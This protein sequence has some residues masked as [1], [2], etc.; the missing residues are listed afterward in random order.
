MAAFRP[1]APGVNSPSGSRP[2]ARSR[3]TAR[4]EHR[5]FPTRETVHKS[6][7][8][9]DRLRGSKGKYSASSIHDYS[10]TRRLSMRSDH[11]TNGCSNPDESR[12]Q[13]GQIQLTHR[14]FHDCEQTD[15]FFGSLVLAGIYFAVCPDCL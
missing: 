11:A 5:L 10:P 2:R 15:S 9:F 13:D 1:A 8:D 12:N 4:A 3:S 7:H 6:S 14:T